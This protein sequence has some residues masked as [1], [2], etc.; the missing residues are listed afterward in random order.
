MNLQR[1]GESGG[2]GHFIEAAYRVM[3][4]REVDPSGLKHYS[5]LV[6]QGGDYV[7]VFQALLESQEFVDKQFVRHNAEPLVRLM[8]AGLLQR[9]PDTEGFLHWAAYLKKTGDI[10]GLVS[11]MA[12]SREAA[13]CLN[14]NLLLQP[15]DHLAYD[16]PALVFLHAEKTAGTT[17]QHMLVRCYGE[18]AVYHEHAD[19]LYYR[20][21]R[22]LAPYSVFAGH[23]NYDSLRYVP[24]SKKL[25]LTVVR[26]PKA[27]LQSLYNFWRAHEPESPLWVSGMELANQLDIMEFLEH[28]EIHEQTGCWNHMTWVVMGDQTWREWKSTLASLTTSPDGNA[29]ASFLKE[30]GMAIQ[31]RLS[32]FLWVGIQEEYDASIRLLFNVLERPHPGEV[33]TDHSLAGLMAQEP[34]FKKAMPVQ[35]ISEISPR[36]AELMELDLILYKKAKTIF[37]K[38]RGFKFGSSD[39]RVGHGS[40]V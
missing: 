11:A 19:T 10:P 9:E 6:G 39:F 31:K 7:A 40:R 18:T 23:F 15:P 22:E 35:R 28:P 5:N 30:A 26:E 13:D 2:I 37:A 1:S 33:P 29:R 25:L 12:G 16:R 21:P 14:R 32:E 27:R 38:R 4:C 24:R 36:A 17:L 34:F 20:S 8:Y 3:L